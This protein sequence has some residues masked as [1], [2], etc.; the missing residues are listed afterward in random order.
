[1]DDEFENLP[2]FMTVKEAAVFAGLSLSDMKR[3]IA[4]GRIQTA[5][6]DSRIFVPTTE[7]IQIQQA[8]HKRN[9]DY[10]AR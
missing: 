8:Q 4:S 7:L 9:K 3:R 10:Y 1:M 2:L 5:I 6:A